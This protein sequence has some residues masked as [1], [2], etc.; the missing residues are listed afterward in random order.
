MLTRGVEAEQLAVV[1]LLPALV[2]AVVFVATGRSRV[3]WVRPVVAALAFG[4]L[5]AAVAITLWPFQLDLSPEHLRDRGNWVPGRGTIGFLTSGDAEQNRLGAR[6]FLANVVLFFP[7]G[8][9]FGIV[10][11][12][13]VG[14][15]AV[16]VALVG[17]AVGLELVQGVTIS[18][19]TLDVDDAIAGSVGVLIGVVAAAV[20]RQPGTR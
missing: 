19:R 17:V 18:Q 10:T 3:S 16:F 9:L 12:R 8:L 11:R 13:W 5:I 6:D 15:V 20:L 2:A 1:W 4:Y 14:I 7:L